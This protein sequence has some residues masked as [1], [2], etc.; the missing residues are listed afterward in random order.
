MEN[1]WFFKEMKACERNL[2]TKIINF[3]RQ[4]NIQY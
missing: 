1:Y 4:R 2:I 3:M